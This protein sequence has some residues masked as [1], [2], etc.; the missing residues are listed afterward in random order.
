MLIEKLR[1]ES[2]YS[3][4]LLYIIVSAGVALVLYGTTVAY[5]NDYLQEYSKRSEIIE[6]DS[7]KYAQRLQ[8][9]IEVHE[10]ERTD[11]DRIA[12]WNEINWY[13]S[14]KVYQNDTVYFDSFLHYVDWTKESDNLTD[15]F[16][17]DGTSRPCFEYPIHFKDGDAILLISGCFF[18]QYEMMIS[19]ASFTVFLVAFL[20]C[21]IFLCRRRFGYIE[22]IHKGLERMNRE[23]PTHQ[24][25]LKGNDELTCLAAY[26]NVMNASIQNQRRLEQEMIEKNREIIAAISHDIRTPLTSVIC[27]LDFLKDSRYENQEVMNRYIENARTRAYQIKGMTEEL[28]ERSIQKEKQKELNWEVLN[29]NEFVSQVISEMFFTLREDG[30]HPDFN[31]DF[32]YAF[33]MKVDVIAF[34][35]VFDNIC[36]NILKYADSTLPVLLTT[37]I[38]GETLEIMEK[39]IKSASRYVESTGIGL[40]NSKKIVQ[41][42]K[43]E[44][45][46]KNDGYYFEVHITLP[47]ILK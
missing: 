20:F 23:E 11:I 2:L 25:S 32:K 31:F 33:E 28:F 46:V 6:Q 15:S 35:R 16:G 44:M 42:H 26:I 38:K 18:Y 29:G 36:S 1:K 30:F 40:Y 47:I 22:E 13:V 24:I 21:F 9:F 27:Y 45:K 19:F 34:R 8:D 14:L 3:Q 43:G 10:L 7:K 12:R 17:W 39:N 5:L 37:E 41:Q 4:V